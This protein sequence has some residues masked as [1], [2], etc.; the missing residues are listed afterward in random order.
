MFNSLREELNKI[1]LMED[2]E[3]ESLEGDNKA[4]GGDDGAADDELYDDED[5]FGEEEEDDILDDVMSGNEDPSDEEINDLVESLILAEQNGYNDYYN[6]DEDYDYNDEDYDDSYDTEDEESNFDEDDDDELEDDSEISVE[7]DMDEDQEEALD[8]LMEAMLG[9]CGDCTD[10]DYVQGS[11]MVHATTNDI[12]GDEADMP[13]NC[14]PP[15]PQ[16]SMLGARRASGREFVD[17][18][19]GNY[20]KYGKV[21]LDRDSMKNMTVDNDDYDEEGDNYDLYASAGNIYDDDENEEYYGIRNRVRTPNLYGKEFTSRY[22]GSLSD[23]FGGSGDALDEDY[24]D[25]D[26][27][28]DYDTGLD[29]SVEAFL[30]N[31]L[32]D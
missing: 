18:G 3:L 17:F 15:S 4:V 16:Y 10:G 29:E 9:E 19:N 21:F 6:E 25:Y 8:G 2:E 12:F 11:R 26:D 30:A 5:F 1:A 13:D 31:Y 27:E 22:S 23:R 32:G 24:D 14:I 28:N 7:D 20:Q